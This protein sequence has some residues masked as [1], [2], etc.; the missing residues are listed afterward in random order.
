VAQ[1]CTVRRALSLLLAVLS[2]AAVLSV[3]TAVAGSSADAGVAVDSRLGRGECALTGRVWVADRGC[4]RRLCIP[5]AK[6][7]KAGHNAELCELR[8]RYG[9]LFAQPIDFRRCGDLG[10][11]WIGDVNACASNPNRARRVIRDAPQCRGA[12]SVYVNHREVE[13]RYDECVTPGRAARLDRLARRQRES[14]NDAA[15]DRNPFNCSYRA[16]W[17]MQDGICV[18]RV[19]PVPDAEQGGFY[20][21]G[22]SVSWRADNELAAREPSWVLDLRPGRRLDELP[23]R[24]DWFRANHAEPDEVVIQLGTNRRRGYSEPGFRR[25][26][27][28]VPATTPVLFLLPFRDFRGDNAA[29]VRATKEAET[30]MRRLAAERPLTCLADWPT[31]ASHHLSNLVDGEHPDDQHEDW[32]ARFVVRAWGRCAADLG[33]SAGRL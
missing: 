17:V 27:A 9:A 3:V 32:Y 29:A 19:G 12:A 24:L 7:F 6:I 2:L 33:R 13:G 5:G 28:T 16:G 21:V 10:R 22:D 31:Y 11:V 15:L 4:A 8:G 1:F 26:M 30:W 25:T 20:M 14:L 18:K 23:G